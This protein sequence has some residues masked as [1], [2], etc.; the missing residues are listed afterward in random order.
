MNHLK[1]IETCTP[2]AS[3]DYNSN[4]NKNQEN[5]TMYHIFIM[6][7]NLFTVIQLKQE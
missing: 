2:L 3:L 6:N 1:T 5:I 7:L 4:T